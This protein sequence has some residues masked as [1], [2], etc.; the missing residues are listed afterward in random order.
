MF[1]PH[2]PTSG[3][4]C[5]H[6][7]DP[8]FIYVTFGIPIALQRRWRTVSMYNY[9]LKLD[10]NFLVQLKMYANMSFNKIRLKQFLY[11][12]FINSY[13]VNPSGFY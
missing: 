4:L 11:G 9:K 5:C 7:T 10:Y 6:D 3:L 2:G 1:W 13:Q 8:N 12:Q